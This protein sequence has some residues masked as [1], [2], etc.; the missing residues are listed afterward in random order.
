MASEE[1]ESLR[2]RFTPLL[3]RLAAETGLAITMGKI[4][5]TKHNAVFAVEAALRGEGGVTMGREA[6]AFLQHAI[7][8]GLQ[9]DDL[10]RDFEHFDKWYRIVGMKPR[11]TKTPVMTKVSPHAPVCV[12]VDDEP[13]GELPPQPS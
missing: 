8:F 6:E 5:Y 10:G 9:P 2:A 13:P 7:Q 4:T 1:V 3:E 12:E 11:S